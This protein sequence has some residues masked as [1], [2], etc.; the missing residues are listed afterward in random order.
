L[1]LRTLNIYTKWLPLFAREVNI[2]KVRN[3]LYTYVKLLIP[4]CKEPPY[5]VS[6]QGYA[7]FVL[8]IHIYFKNKAEP[9]KIVFQY[10]LFLHTTEPVNH[11]RC[12]KLT[13]QNP[14]EEFKKKL[15]KAGGV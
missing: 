8:P 2:V 7:G 10:N 4:E 9:R 3:Y 13:F 1:F 11:S 12:E 15:L 5:H 14:T 6:E